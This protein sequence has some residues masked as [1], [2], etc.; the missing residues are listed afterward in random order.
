MGPKI[1]IRK[2]DDTDEKLKMIS[3][4]IKELLDPECESVVD[5]EKKFRIQHKVI[6]GVYKGHLSKVELEKF[7]RSRINKTITDLLISHENGSKADPYAHTHFVVR[8]K[9]MW[10][11]TDCRRLDFMDIHPRI[12]GFKDGLFKK[13]WNYICKEDNKD[14][15]IGEAKSIVESV[16]SCNTVSDAL[17]KNCTS[18]ASATG[19]I[20]LYSHR[21]VVK[22]KMEEVSLFKWQAKLVAETAGDADPRKIIWYVDEK[23]NT[24]KSWL[25]DWMVGKFGNKWEVMSGCGIK[26]AATIV[27]GM[28]SSGWS[29][30]GIFLDLTRTQESHNG[31]YATIESMKNAR[32][33]ATKYQGKS[34]RFPKV[35]HVV[36]LANWGPDTSALSEDRW[37]IRRLGWKD[38]VKVQPKGL[39]EEVCANNITRGL[40]HNTGAT[41]RA[42]RVRLENIPVDYRLLEQCG[43]RF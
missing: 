11:T 28:V 25:A 12:A 37:D 29:S 20:A 22:S 5:P 35:P 17:M 13:Q 40:A 9:E 31:F 34:F 16:W 38:K 8:C 43:L 1:V 3:Q 33:T 2:K 30:H 4:G 36:V 10:Q 23:G 19:V 32:M 41:V 6:T 21:P 42:S 27:L 15:K 39:M 24:G 26:D 7:L 18:A 14:K